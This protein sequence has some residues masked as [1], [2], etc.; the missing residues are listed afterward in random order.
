MKLPVRYDEDNTLI[1]DANGHKIAEIWDDSIQGDLS[2]EHIEKGL[3]ALGN[4]IAAALNGNSQAIA[5]ELAA[6]IEDA[7]NGK[8]LVAVENWIEEVLNEK[9]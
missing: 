4:Q 9:T 7:P 3:D 6:L 2:P 8:K 1:L 5:R